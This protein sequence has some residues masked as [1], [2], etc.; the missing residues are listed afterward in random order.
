MNKEIFHENYIS[1]LKFFLII[2][3]QSTS[4]FVADNFYLESNLGSN[5]LLPPIIFR[6]ENNEL[7]SF[8]MRYTTRQPY[9][10]PHFYY[11]RN[12][13]HIK[14][15]KNVQDLTIFNRVFIHCIQWWITFFLNNENSVMGIIHIFEHFSIFSGLKPNKFKCEIAGI[16]VLRGPN[17]TLRC[18]MC[19]L[20]N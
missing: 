14:E 5:C 4:K 12:T 18:G 3:L 9:F 7:L 20:Q 17:D 1:L 8:K 2:V 11:L 13:F 6:A 10:N 15:I 16:G 19:N